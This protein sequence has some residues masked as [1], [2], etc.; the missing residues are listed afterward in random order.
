MVEALSKI[1]TCL[2]RTAG[3]FGFLGTVRLVHVVRYGG[4]SVRLVS[5]PSVPY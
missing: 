5:V 3:R 2:V 4:R 1:Q